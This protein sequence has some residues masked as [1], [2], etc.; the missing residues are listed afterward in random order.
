MKSMKKKFIL[1]FARV[2]KEVC[3]DVN[4]SDISHV[5]SILTYFPHVQQSS[6][7]YCGFGKANNRKSEDD[8]VTL[9]KALKSKRMRK[10]FRLHVQHEYSLENMVFLV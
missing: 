8:D 7:Y 3:K 9:L 6:V 10:S 2:L 4:T 1:Y 5:K